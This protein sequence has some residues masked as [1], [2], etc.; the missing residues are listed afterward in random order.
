MVFMHL[1]LKAVIPNEKIDIILLKNPTVQTGT[2][3]M[4][5]QY[6][7]MTQDGLFVY[8]YGLE[9]ISLQ[10]GEIEIDLGG[11]TGIN[12]TKFQML[13]KHCGALYK[14]MVEM[15]MFTK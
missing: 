9:H 10:A 8:V 5:V 11:A 12:D 13:K 3:L 6:P 14:H 1:W 4:T 15:V 7:P 2:G